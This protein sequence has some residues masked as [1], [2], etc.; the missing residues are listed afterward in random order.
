M[1]RR[2]V[3]RITTRGTDPLC[4]RTL[5]VGVSIAYQISDTHPNIIE[6][7]NPTPK[8]TVHRSTRRKLRSIRLVY[9]LQI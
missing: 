2:E 9:Y 7:D 1:T 4:L 8:V 5:T 6:S 3:E